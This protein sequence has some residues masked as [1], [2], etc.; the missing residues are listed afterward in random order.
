MS[1]FPANLIV[2]ALWALLTAAVAAGTGAEILPA[3]AVAFVL[4]LLLALPCTFV[5][6]LFAAVI[7]SW[8]ERSPATTGPTR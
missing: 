8:L 5:L 2:P 1:Y 4:T 3:A 7:R 6:G